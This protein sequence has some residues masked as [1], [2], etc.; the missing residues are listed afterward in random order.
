MHNECED[1]V[2]NIE[3]FNHKDVIFMRAYLKLNKCIYDYR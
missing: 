3:V 1:Q 2:Q